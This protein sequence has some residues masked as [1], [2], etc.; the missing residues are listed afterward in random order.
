MF[1]AFSFYLGIQ[2]PG[3]YTLQCS[4]NARVFYY[5]SQLTE[6]L[7]FMARVYEPSSTNCENVTLFIQFVTSSHFQPSILV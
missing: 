2:T 7:E 4:P 5:V 6:P 3:L 1:N